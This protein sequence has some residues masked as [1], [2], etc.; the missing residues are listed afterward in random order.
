[1]RWGG[2]GGEVYVAFGGWQIA[3]GRWIIAFEVYLGLM[4]FEEI[5]IANVTNVP[6]LT[7]TTKQKFVLFVYSSHS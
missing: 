2:D 3:D 1:M 4:Q 7:N 5:F 6:N